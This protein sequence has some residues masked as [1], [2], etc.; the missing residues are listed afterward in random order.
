MVNESQ[1][2]KYGDQGPFTEEEEKAI[3]A[4]LDLMEGIYRIA[5][6]DLKFQSINRNKIS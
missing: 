6:R 2:K 5:I 1:L 4:L 3:Q